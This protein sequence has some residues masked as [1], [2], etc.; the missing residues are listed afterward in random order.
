MYYVAETN[1]HG[2]PFWR[3]KIQL[4]SINR[5][6]SNSLSL[7]T[8][9]VRGFSLLFGINSGPCCLKCEVE[10]ENFGQFKIW[11]IFTQTMIENAWILKKS[12]FCSFNSISSAWKLCSFERKLAVQINEKIMRKSVYVREPIGPRLSIM[13]VRGMCSF[14]FSVYKVN[15]TLYTHT[16]S[17]AHSRWNRLVVP[18]MYHCAT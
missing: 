4:F 18:N 17:H 5:S 13:V 10:T 9:C 8:C 3:K 14:K 16:H 12:N 15:S 6:F 11:E 1:W 7:Y 2:S